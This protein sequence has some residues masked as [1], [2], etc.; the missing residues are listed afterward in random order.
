MCTC[1][2]GVGG[3]GSVIIEN[4]VFVKKFVYFVF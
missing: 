2:V 1:V 3:S 4:D